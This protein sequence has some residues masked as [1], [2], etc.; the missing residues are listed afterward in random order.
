MLKIIVFILE[1]KNHG[2]KLFS[3]G[4]KMEDVWIY[5][6]IIEF[7]KEF[8]NGDNSFLKHCGYV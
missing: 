8:P 3:N 1:Q 2:G 4:I 6:T 5:S 7:V